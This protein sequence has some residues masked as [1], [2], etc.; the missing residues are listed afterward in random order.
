MLLLILSFHSILIFARYCPYTL[1]VSVNAYVL[2]PLEGRIS[3]E[4]GW[5]YMGIISPMHSI[6]S[7]SLQRLPIPPSSLICGF[8]V[9]R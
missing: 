7:S 4:F 2:I 1:L 6:F 3:T 8:F 9:I 5:F